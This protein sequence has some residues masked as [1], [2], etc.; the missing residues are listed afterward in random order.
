M[1]VEVRADEIAVE[2][3]RKVAASLAQHDAIVVLHKVIG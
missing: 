3:L 1:N 2:A